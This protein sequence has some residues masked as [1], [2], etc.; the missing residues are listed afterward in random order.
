MTVTSQK[1][2]TGLPPGIVGQ[3]VAVEIISQLL[4]SGRLP[5]TLLLSGPGGVGK[6][7]TALQIAKYFHCDSDKA[8]DCQC[9]GC[10]SIRTGNHSDVMVLSRDRQ[11]GIDEMREIVAIAGLK[12]SEG[13][14]KLIIIDKAEYIT[15]G[16]ANASL[17]ALEEPGE[18]VRFILI[19]D[20]P[21]KLLSTVRSR[22]YHLRFG[23]LSLDSMREFARLIGDNPGDNETERN[24]A[25]SFNRPGIYLRLSFSESYRSTIENLIDWLNELLDSRDP[26]SVAD[27]VRW[28]EEFWKYADSLS[29]LEHKAVI[30]RGANAYEIRDFRNDPVKNPIS[31][32]NFRIEAT[33][34][35]KAQFWTQGRKAILLA[36]ALRRNLSLEKSDINVR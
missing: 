10:R 32:V 27:A 28:K 1:S 30:P 8:P 31:P 35:R 22:S 21:A 12:S 18:H 19:T 2:T 26:V 25:M 33:S 6:L 20:T 4:T 16:G 7:A 13:A 14:E 24:I 5:G 15:T 9:A 11:I 17:K 34:K 36:D 23:L 3:Q 29:E